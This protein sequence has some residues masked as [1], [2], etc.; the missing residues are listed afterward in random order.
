MANYINNAHDNNA[1]PIK[2]VS[3]GIYL[4]G[5]RKVT[6]KIMAGKLVVRVGGG[7]TSVEEYV[8]T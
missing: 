3:A 1:L 8:Q 7:Y 2:R 6:A 4:I 5:S